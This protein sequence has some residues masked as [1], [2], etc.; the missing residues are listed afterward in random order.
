LYHYIDSLNQKLIPYSADFGL[1]KRRKPDQFFSGVEK[2]KIMGKLGCHSR[3]Y[4]MVND[5]G[6][7]RNGSIDEVDDDRKD[8]RSNFC[9]PSACPL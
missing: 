8:L 5:T 1:A 3:D 2:F 7:S 9:T 4:A 6:N